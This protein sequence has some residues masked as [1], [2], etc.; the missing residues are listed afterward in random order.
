MP[1]T[2]LGHRFTEAIS[3]LSEGAPVDPVQ[4]QDLRVP[5]ANR[6]PELGQDRSCQVA[7]FGPETLDRWVL[8]PA[9]ELV[10]FAE[11]QPLDR[12]SGMAASRIDQRVTRHGEQPVIEVPETGIQVEAMQPGQ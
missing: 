2:D 1:A 8:L 4:V 9:G 6:L 10:L 7:H 5:L 12:V 3:D 11:T